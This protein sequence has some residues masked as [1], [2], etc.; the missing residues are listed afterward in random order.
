MLPPTKRLNYFDHQFLRVDDFVDEQAYHLGMRRAH[1]RMFHTPGVAYGLGV[2]Y[3]GSTLTVSAGV[4]LDG[5]GREIVLSEN[6]EVPVPADLA[7]HTAWLTIAYGER[8]TDHTAETGAAGDR[9]WEELPTLRV[10]AEAPDDPE[11]RLVLARV[12]VATDGKVAGTDDGEGEARRR[13]AGP[14]SMGLEVASLTVE[15]DVRAGGQVYDRS[16]V[17]FPAGG[18]IMWSGKAKEIPQ[19]W[20]L[21]DGQ[22]GT[23]DLRGRFV[24]G[25]HPEDQDYSAVG[26]TGG[27]AQVVLAEM[28]MPAHQHEG[29][30]TESGLHQHAIE[31]TRGTDNRRRKLPGTA[32]IWLSYDNN[33]NRDP[34]TV[35]G[36]G[37]VITDQIGAHTH[38]LIISGAGGGKPHENRPPYYVLAY[39]MKQ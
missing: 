8:T 7:G 4:A 33:E 39:I 9:R 21:C 25:W 5:D 12:T 10:D 17:V 36:R 24:V 11:N 2:E 6:D 38:S 30:T 18:I 16:G 27:A 31:G 34:G 3:S 37:L 19:G 13:V 28:H 20:L 15:R 29:K 22:N 23:P 14:R 1:N 32:A 26:V 35:E